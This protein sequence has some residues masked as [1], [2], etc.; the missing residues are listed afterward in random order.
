MKKVKLSALSKDTIVLVDGYS[1]INTV[2]DVLEDLESYKSKTIYTT[3]EHPASFDA[4]GILD[5]A[6]DNEYENGMY[7][8][9]DESIKA[10]ITKDDIEELQ[11]IFDRILARTPGQNI[12][13]EADKLIEIDI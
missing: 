10:D 13:Y 3:T 8:D 6:I 4:K 2:S 5:D 11:K 1:T 9:W 12:A 7:E